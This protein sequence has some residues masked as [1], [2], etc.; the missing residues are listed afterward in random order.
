MI[1]RRLLCH[2]SARSSYPTLQHGMYVRHIFSTINTPPPPLPLSPP[3]QHGLS[4]GYTLT[5]LCHP[6][7]QHGLSVSYTLTRLR[8]P[9]RQLVCL[10]CY[11]SARFTYR[12]CHHGP[13]AMLQGSTLQSSSTS[14]WSVSHTAARFS[15]PARHQGLLATLQPDSIIQRVTMVC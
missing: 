10:P 15:H 5:R 11:S 3:C 4:G 7:R 1:C 9:T 8:H 12:T 6:T 13:Y 14:P 2:S